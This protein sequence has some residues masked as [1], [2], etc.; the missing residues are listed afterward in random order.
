MNVWTGFLRKFHYEDVYVSSIIYVYVMLFFCEYPNDV[1]K[2]MGMLGPNQTGN[3]HISEDIMYLS[4][5]S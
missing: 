2:Q 1:P 3:M 4:R 5:S